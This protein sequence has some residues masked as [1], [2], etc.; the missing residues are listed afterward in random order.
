MTLQFKTNI[1]CNGCINTVTPFLNSIQGIER[2]E[3]NLNDPDRILTV[4]ANEASS[5]EIMEA[6]EKAGYKIE[7]V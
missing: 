1:K 4:I 7:P 3:V 5:P 6:I 2:W